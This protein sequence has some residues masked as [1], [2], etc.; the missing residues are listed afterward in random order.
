[1]STTLCFACI[2][3]GLEKDARQELKQLTGLFHCAGGAA[4]SVPL[5]HI[6]IIPL[7]QKECSLQSGLFSPW[8]QCVRDHQSLPFPMVWLFYKESN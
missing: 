2:N 7:Q 3:L 8:P 4:H 6:S 5:I 1:M